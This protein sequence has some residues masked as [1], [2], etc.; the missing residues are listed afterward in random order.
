MDDEPFN[1][2]G[3]KIIIR[4]AFKMLQIDEDLMDEIGD[5]ASNGLESL[6]MVKELHRKGMEYAIIITDCS[7]PH[8]DG[9]EATIKIRK[10]CEM[11]RLVQPYII[12][13]TGHTE[14]QYIQ[15]AWN[16]LMDEIVP[17]PANIDTLASIIQSLIVFNNN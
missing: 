11:H 14:E 8:M 7:M 13:C 10:H 1:L 15:K 4:H 9:Y 17:K 2:M 3:L 16:H 6:N 5:T 12:A